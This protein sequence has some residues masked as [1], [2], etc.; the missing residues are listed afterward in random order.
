M[1]GVES[2]TLLLHM[3]V[4]ARVAAFAQTQVLSAS[5]FLYEEVSNWNV[6]SL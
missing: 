1:R 4:K 2:H 6:N 3:A 5:V